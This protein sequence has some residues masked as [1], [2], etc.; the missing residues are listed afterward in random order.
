M[1]FMGMVFATVF[2][3]LFIVHIS[4]TIL[5]FILAIVLKIVG[6]VKD[7]RKMKIAGNVFLVLGILFAV[8]VIV[9][10]LYLVFTTV[11]WSVTLPDGKTK[12]VLTRDVSVMRSYAENPDESSLKELEKL[13]DKNSD[14]VFWHDNN[15]YSV[16]D[17]GLQVG[18]A[19]VVRLALEHGA[20]FDNPERYDR[21]A[22]VATSM[23]YYLNICVDRSITEGDVEIAR[24]MFENNAS[25]EL[26]KPRDYYSNVFGKAVWAV[27]YNDDAVTDTEL[28]FIQVFIDN[29]FSSDRSFLPLEEVPSNNHFSDKYY[30]N[31]A[32]A[33]KSSNYDRL[34]KLIGR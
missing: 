33:E 29:G 2:V 1:A 9:F 27:L 23:D 22:Y 17:M 25:M 34:M 6:K 5:F 10:I 28:E 13:L 31:A 7:S 14:L 3:V 18:S 12:Y 32:A 21:M 19:D 24:M 11:F 26:K 16:L 20:I 8:P 4:L 30:D 15:H